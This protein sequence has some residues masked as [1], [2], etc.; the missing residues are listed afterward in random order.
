MVIPVPPLS[1]YLEQYLQSRRCCHER[2]SNFDRKVDDISQEFKVQLANGHRLD[3][4]GIWYPHRRRS[5]LSN[6]HLK[7]QIHQVLYMYCQQTQFPYL[8]TLFQYKLMAKSPKPV[9][10]M[11]CV[12]FM[13]TFWDTAMVTAKILS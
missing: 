7:M 1:T 5:H 10:L 8:N 9:F 12:F 2:G 3:R 6:N 13:P 4:L 11:T